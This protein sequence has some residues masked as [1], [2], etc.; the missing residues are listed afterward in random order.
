MRHAAHDRCLKV[1]TK[2]A[3]NEVARVCCVATEACRI[4]SNGR[5]FLKRRG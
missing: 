3:R 1:R 4:A 5:E 2:L